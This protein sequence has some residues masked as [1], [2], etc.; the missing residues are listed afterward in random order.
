MYK[1]YLFDLDG[2]LLPMDMKYFVKL[3]VAAYCKK[4]VPIT[5]INAD[6]LM[7]AI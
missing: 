4:M 6:T 3:F 1:N 5:K 7:D 2:T